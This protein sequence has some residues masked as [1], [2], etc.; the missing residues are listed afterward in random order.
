MK[1]FHYYIA[2]IF[3]ACLLFSGCETP[4]AEPSPETPNTPAASA[5]QPSP[6]TVIQNVKNKTDEIQEIY[7]KHNDTLENLIDNPDAPI[8]PPAENAP[9]ETSATSAFFTEM[10]YGEFSDEPDDEN[11]N[12]DENET[13]EPDLDFSAPPAGYVDEE[14]YEDDT[15]I[16][17]LALGEILGENQKKLVR[18][19]PKMAIWVDEE[20]TKVVL[21]GWICQ[22]RVPLEF[23]LC[24]GTGVIRTFTYLSEDGTPEKMVM[25]PGAKTHESVVCVDVRPTIIHTALLAIGAKSGEHVVFYPE[26]RAPSG[27]EIVITLRWLDENK[28]IVERR[29]QDVIKEISSEAPMQTSWVFAGSMFYAD[30]EGV[31]YYAADSSGEIVSVS[32]FPSAMIDVPFSSSGENADLLFLAD[33]EKLPPRGTP[34]TILLERK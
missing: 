23:F 29:A 30:E 6:I 20:K 5:A 25:F 9:T 28:K 3:G 16:E 31:Q 15:T 14:D 1:P 27:D 22:T 18:L 19:N 32:N 17:P 21:Q 2:L 10:Q 4:K 11:K 7:K 33:E 24:T 12:D 8:S 13:E 34:V 26:F